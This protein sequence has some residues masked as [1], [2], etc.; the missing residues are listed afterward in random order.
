MKRLFT[1]RFHKLT[2]PQNVAHSRTRFAH[3][4]DN[5]PELNAVINDRYVAIHRLQRKKST[6]P[7]FVTLVGDQIYMLCSTIARS[8][9]FRLSDEVALSKQPCKLLVS[10]TLSMF[11]SSSLRTIMADLTCAI[12]FTIAPHTR[13][14]LRCICVE[15]TSMQVYWLQQHARCFLAPHFVAVLQ[16]LN[17]TMFHRLIYGRRARRQV[18]ERDI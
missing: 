14:V 3:F 6:A 5:Q 11:S 15:K 16:I 2:L 18:S 17:H 7:T 8:A 9:L 10:T 12:S 4:D 13:S 1:S